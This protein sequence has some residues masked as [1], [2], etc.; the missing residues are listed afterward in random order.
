MV[1]TD[2][3]STSP[4]W[5]SPN[6]TSAGAVTWQLS[7]WFYVRDK[8]E[9]EYTQLL[10]GAAVCTL[11]ITSYYHVMYSN[12]LLLLLIRD[13]LS[14]FWLLT[15]HRETDRHIQEYLCSNVNIFIYFI[16]LMIITWKMRTMLSA[17]SDKYLNHTTIQHSNASNVFI[18]CS[19]IVMNA[20]EMF[21]KGFMW[22]SDI[23]AICLNDSLYTPMTHPLHQ[24]T[25]KA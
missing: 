22:H 2:G 24:H 10:C 14:M 3:H 6:T 17:F 25:I 16:R 7:F 18:K 9:H 15:W 12:L 11:V 19:H 23:T 21:M 13:T 1:R 5:Q 20:I 8:F 4:I